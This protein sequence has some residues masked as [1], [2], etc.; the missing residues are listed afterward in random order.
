M[1]NSDVIDVTDENFD[2]E[3]L[4]AD[5]PVLIDFTATWCGPCKLLVPIVEKIARD[6]AGEIKVVKVDMDDAP[7]A[8]ARFGVR[9][10]PTLMVFVAGEKRRVHVGL[11][12]REKI[13]ELLQ[14]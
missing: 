10:A 4:Q 3:V 9:A 1:K 13:D 7:H 12:S 5:K 2:T 11:T 6:R 8:T 14:V